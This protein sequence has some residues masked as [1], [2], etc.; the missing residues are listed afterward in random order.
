MDELRSGPPEDMHHLKFTIP[1]PDKSPGKL[2]GALTSFLCKPMCCLLL[3]YAD[4]DRQLS[5]NY[6][7]APVSNFEDL[8]ETDLSLKSYHD[9]QIRITSEDTVIA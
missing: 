7:A 8:S 9:N 5:P 2:P 6:S 3:C 4:N 1:V